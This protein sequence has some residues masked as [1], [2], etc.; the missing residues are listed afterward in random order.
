M[1]Q[2]VLAL[3]LCWLT[4]PVLA[5]QQLAK[6]RQNSYLTKVFRL[7]EAQTRRLYE[8]GL[9]SARPDFFT[10][11]VDSFRTDEPM[12]RWRPLPLGYYL[13]AHTEGPQLVYWLRAETS[14]TVE[15]IDN[16]R[17]LSLTVRD[18]LGRLL[19]NAQVAVAGRPLPYDPA[20]HAY[21][22]TRGRRAGL[23][24]VTVG[25]R[26]TFHPL[27]SPAARPRGSWALRAGRR[28]LFGRPLG[29]LTVP[30]WRTAQALRHPAQATTGL[31]G[32]LRSPFSE[33]LRDQR[34][35]QR[36]YQNRERWLSYLVVS[37]PRYRP[38]GDT[39]RLKARV[40]RRSNGRP[41]T[42]P[43]TLWLN[44]GGLGRRKRLATLRPVRPGSYEYSLPL[45]DTLGL[46][47][48]TSVD[49][50]LEDSQ[51]HNVAEGSFRYEDYELKNDH[52][53]L[54][55]LAK[56]PWRGQPQAVF[57]RGSDANELNLPDARVRLAVL[58]A[59]APGRLPTRR[60]FLPDTLWTHAQL[61]DPLGE[62]RVN[63]PPRIFPDLDLSYAV[64]ATFLTSDNERHVETISL[65]Y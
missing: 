34:R 31:V 58:P 57:L 19:P 51:E 60:L 24:A 61:L 3:L 17:D 44:G 49:L 16:Q 23:V 54:R 13:V 40:L 43:L 9:P 45:T 41:S 12:A 25:G 50:Y 1:Y 7:T 38:T 65:P 30:V 53:A 22:R 35:D 33:D 59:A 29:Y 4:L 8:R 14:R 2:L 28:V 48:D 11:V 15:V 10:V 21:R 20:T 63:I 47:V 52:Y 46:R 6:A 64:Q 56:E 55:L 18:S 42:Q 36:Q 27:A 62:T 39:L 32:L 26:T 37:Q 5:Q